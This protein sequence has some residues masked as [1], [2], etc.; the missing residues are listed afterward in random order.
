MIHFSVGRGGGGNKIDVVSD[1]GVICGW[2]VVLGYRNRVVGGFLGA[3]LRHFFRGREGGGG[4]HKI[5]V[6]GGFAAFPAA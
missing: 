1:F 3:F 2:L 6:V 5:D 4:G